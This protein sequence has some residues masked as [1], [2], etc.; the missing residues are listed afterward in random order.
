MSR[1]P[2]VAPGYLWVDAEFSS[3]ELEEAEILQVAL[4]ATDARL[5]R[6][7][8]PEKDLVL[9]IQRKDD[10]GISPWVKEHIPHV[11]RG[12]LG[13]TAVPLADAEVKLCRYIDA[14]IGPIREKAEERPLI[15]G[16]SVHND[17]LLLRRFFPGVLRRAH[18]RLLDVSTLKTQWTDHFGG[19]PPDKKDP[20]FV[21]KWFPEA[22][23]REGMGEHDAH[24]D[25]QA[26]V[27]ELAYYRAQLSGGT[28]RNASTV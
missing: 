20:A 22:I 10:R 24:Y 19:Q 1:A 25:I 3:L 11:V 14:V 2:G 12:C 5:K 27:A 9:F 23:L 28:E 26:S 21:R 18:Y 15:A 7:A 4:M 17:W 13:P 6:L 8:P 16:N